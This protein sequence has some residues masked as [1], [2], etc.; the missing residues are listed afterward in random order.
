MEE[1]LFLHAPPL[2]PQSQA[3]PRAKIKTPP[4]PQRKTLQPQQNPPNQLPKTCSP[5]HSWETTESSWMAVRAQTRPSLDSACRRL[6]FEVPKNAG[7][8]S[9]CFFG[10]PFSEKNDGFLLKEHRLFGGQDMGFWPGTSRADLRKKAESSNKSNST[11]IRW[12]VLSSDD[13]KSTR[14]EIKQKTFAP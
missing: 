11:G 7:F 6:F 1:F 10:V 4:P 2:S 3:H 14:P 13:W 8:L 9:V 12:R 5:R